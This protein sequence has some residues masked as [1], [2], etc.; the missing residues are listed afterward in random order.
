MQNYKVVLG[1]NVR[2]SVR[3]LVLNWVKG[4]NDDQQLQ[5]STVKVVQQTSPA[6]RLMNRLH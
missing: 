2:P 5:H 3:Q 4:Q 6:L 1:L